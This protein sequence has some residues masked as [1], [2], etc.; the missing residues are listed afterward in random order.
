MG[1]IRRYIL[2]TILLVAIASCKK[3]VGEYNPNFEGEWYT[4]TLVQQNTGYQIQNYLNINPDNS[5]YGFACDI[6]CNPCGCMDYYSGKALINSKH[7]RLRIGNSS[8]TTWLKIQEEPYI[9]SFG[10]WTMKINDLNY[11]KQ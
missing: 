6:S 2:F 8:N 4:D 11:Y 10:I 1:K 9:N 7:T 5:E 3:Y